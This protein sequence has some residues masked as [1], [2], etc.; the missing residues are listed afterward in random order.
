M[1]GIFWGERILKVAIIAD[2]HAN[3]VALQAVA[4]DLQLWKPDFIV[5]AGDIV[6]RGPKPLDCFQYVRQRQQRD[7]WLLLGGNHEDFIVMLADELLDKNRHPVDPHRYK[8]YRPVYWTS[9][10]LLPELDAIRAL[11]F[12]QTLNAP[13]GSE[14]R[15]VHA[16]MRGNRDGIYPETSSATLRDQIAPPPAAFCAGHTHRPLVRRID[17]TL[18]VNVGSVGL[19]FDG[20]TRAAYGRIEWLGG[21]WSGSIRRVTYDLQSA[22]HDFVKTGFMKEGGPLTTIMLSEL[23]SARSLLYVWTK[24]YEHLVLSGQITM[25][26]AVTDYLISLA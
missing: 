12:S 14:L 10:Q 22:E 16:S 17:G 9:R 24:H 19:P 15:I 8:F 25:A 7:G 26:Q 2:I 13:D 4:A 1:A 23:R 5:V 18:V 3:M 21:E 6:N 11:P 20:D